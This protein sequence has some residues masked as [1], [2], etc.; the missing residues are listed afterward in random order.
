MIAL[1]PA[2]AE[3]EGGDTGLAAGGAGLGIGAEIADEKNGVGH[4]A[5]SFRIVG[6]VPIDGAPAMA[7]Q[8]GGDTERPAGPGGEPWE[9]RLARAAEAKP[10][11]HGPGREGLPA[12]APAIGV[13]SRWE[14]S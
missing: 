6:T 3:A 9:T 8:P 7:R 10:E 1:G 2:G 5:C 11:Q 13:S 4:G 14:W 12:L